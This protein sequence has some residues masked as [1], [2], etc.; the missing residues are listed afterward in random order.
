MGRWGE[1]ERAVRRHNVKASDQRTVFQTDRDRILYSSA[2]HRLAGVTQIVRVGEE[3]IFHTR[4]Q[5]SIKVAQVGRRLAEHV[6]N[7]YPAISK[8]VGVHPEVVEAACLAHDLGHPPFGHCGESE[9]NT[10]VIGA[11]V[12]DGFEGNAQSFRILSKLAVRFDEVPGLDL[13]RATLAATLK[14][15]WR[16]EP[17]SISKNG[18]WGAYKLEID[19]LR[20][21][22]E[23]HDDDTPTVEASLMDWAD[24]IA[25]SVHDLEDFHRCGAIPWMELRDRDKGQQLVERALANWHMPPANARDLLIEAYQE[26]SEFIGAVFGAALVSPY[27]GTRSQR[28]TLR[29]M[30]SSLVQRFITAVRLEDGDLGFRV[31]NERI[32][33]VKI[34][35]QITKHYIIENPSLMAQQMGHRKI[36]RDVFGIINDRSKEGPAS[37]L[38]KR[39][40]YIWELCEGYS[41]RFSADCISSLTEKQ[42]VSLWGRLTGYSAGSV[43]DPIVR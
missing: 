18:K 13:S 7:T 31:S 42:L 36:I 32:A 22:R 27:E 33:E 16:R 10:L 5:H 28:L 30:T 24:D 19:D 11:G 1:S 26:L 3:D 14:Y 9:L 38:P 4:Y 43:L 2:F 8:E 25:Y 35:K 41:A 12:E 39:L 40:H 20:F 15:P 21:A 29:N 17:K 37:F 6:L 23:Y 34:L